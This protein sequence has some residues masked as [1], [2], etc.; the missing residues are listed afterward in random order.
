[1]MTPPGP[2]GART[3]PSEEERRDFRSYAWGIALA[4]LLTLVPFALVHWAGVRPLPLLIVIGVFAL[5]QGIVHLRFFLHIRF[6]GKRD[7]LQ[8]I[9]FSTLVLIIMVGGTVWIMGNLALR[10]GMPAQP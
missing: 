7:D 4:L 9:L 6:S 2:A 8:L 3:T 10:M 1:M 5:G